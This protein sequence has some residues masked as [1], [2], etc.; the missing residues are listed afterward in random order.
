LYRSPVHP[1][2]SDLGTE[3]KR[4]G[5]DYIYSEAILGRTARRLME[6]YVPVPEKYFSSL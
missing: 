1:R 6:G 4:Q 2:K 3:L 5:N